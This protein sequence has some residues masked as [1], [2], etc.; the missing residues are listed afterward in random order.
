MKRTNF[1]YYITTGVLLGLLLIPPEVVQAQSVVHDPATLAKHVQTWIEEAER[2]TQTVDQYA[3]VYENMVGQLK[4]LT[5]HVGHVA[6]QIT[7]VNRISSLLKGAAGLYASLRRLTHHRMKAL[8]DIETLIRQGKFDDAAFRRLF[9][10]YARHT[11]GRS[12][13]DTL[14]SLNRLARIDTELAAWLDEKQSVEASLAA[15]TLDVQALQKQL[16]EELMLPTN[17]Q[18]NI[19]NLNDQIINRFNVIEQYTARYSEL[20]KLITERLNRH[21]EKFQEMENFARQVRA[22]NNAWTSLI[23]TKGEISR[24]LDRIVTGQ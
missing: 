15:M 24:T 22:T 10:E 20:N 16:D 14:A 12:T 17:R 5:T 1:S 21:G 18:R 23:R 6:N 4:V 2:W 3:R 13:R 7:L 19:A 11:M 8:V 9:D